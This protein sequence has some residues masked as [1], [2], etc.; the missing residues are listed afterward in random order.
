[1]AE[2]RQ[3]REDARHRVLADP[4][5]RERARGRVPR[6]VPI[7]LAEARGD[8]A[9]GGRA[10]QVGRADQ[11]RAAR[12][13]VEVRERTAELAA[14]SGERAGPQR[15]LGGRR[16]PAGRE[17]VDRGEVRRVRPRRAPARLEPL[18]RRAEAARHRLG[19]GAVV[20][21]R[22]AQEEQR[23]VEAG[24]HLCRSVAAH[25]AAVRGALARRQR[26]AGAGR[27][28]GER[29]VEALG[30]ELVAGAVGGTALDPVLPALDGAVDD[31]G[32]LAVLERRGATLRG[33]Q[34]LEVA[35]VLDLDHVPVVEVDE[36][37]RRPLHVV[38]GRVALAADAVRVDRGLVPVDVQD[39]VVERRGARRRQGLGHAAR[40]EAALALDHVHA[41][42]VAAVAVARGEREP[43]RAGDADPGG[44][45]RQ[46][47][48][49]RRRRRVAVERPGPV[50]HEQRRG[51]RR[52]A[53]KAEQVLEP[54]PV[55]QLAGEQRR[56]AHARHLVAQRPQRVEAHRLVARGVRDDVGVLAVGRGELVLGRVEQDARD[57]TSRGDRAAGVAR[58]RHVVVEKRAQRA[59]EEVE[60]LEARQ[61]LGR[62]R[63]GFGSA[64][65]D[66]LGSPGSKCL[67]HAAP[68]PRAARC[69]HEPLSPFS[70]VWDTGMMRQ[71]VHH[72]C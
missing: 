56:A 55:A 66:P 54:E 41:R 53:A 44:A 58:H 68:P 18:V 42:G 51:G 15:Q 50:L 25:L 24:L 29:L 61:L 2:A 46:P 23:I 1:M 26:A 19:G 34:L 6:G 71:T 12:G 63:R 21:D 48:E 13:L 60:A 39:E 43:D 30:A 4:A 32:R 52:V 7:A 59:V 31:R 3:A 27:Q 11:Q 65:A 45:G 67:P 72:G 70:G 10:E 22:L 33:Q 9:D 17:L 37:H 64:D 57:E 62:Q 14:E 16:V 35:P 20:L 38:A 28:L 49:R 40:R 47:H 36:L 69:P 8:R 5:D